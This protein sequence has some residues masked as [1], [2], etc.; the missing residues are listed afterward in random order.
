MT[1]AMD[2]LQYRVICDTCGH[3][4]VRFLI[5]EQKQELEGTPCERPWCSGHYKIINLAD[6]G[7]DHKTPLNE[8]KSKA[9]KE[10]FFNLPTF[11]R[12]AYREECLLQQQEKSTNETQKQQV[13]YMPACPKCGC[14][15]LTKYISTAGRAASVFALGLASPKIGKTYQCGYC[16]HTW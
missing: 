11:D 13:N 7:Y 12:N 2:S 8:I 6:F 9:I 1:G 5:L 15:S 10:K 3:D 14:V 4:D 16:R